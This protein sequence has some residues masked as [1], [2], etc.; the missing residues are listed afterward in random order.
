MLKQQNFNIC[1]ILEH[2]ILHD[3]MIM[4]FQ[5]IGECF[6]INHDNIFAI[7]SCFASN[8]LNNATF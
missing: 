5:E 1:G 4:S 2:V 6:S 3:S 7:I 8:K